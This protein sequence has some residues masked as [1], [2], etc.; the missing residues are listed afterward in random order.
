MKNENKTKTLGGSKMENE[1][2]TFKTTEVSEERI[3]RFPSP[4]CHE[5][6]VSNLSDMKIRAALSTREMAGSEIKLKSVRRVRRSTPDFVV[7]V[8]S[9]SRFDRAIDT[10]DGKKIVGNTGGCDFIVSPLADR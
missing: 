9:Y 1:T 5:T 10:K 3:F 8:V 6:R 2:I 4:L 7:L